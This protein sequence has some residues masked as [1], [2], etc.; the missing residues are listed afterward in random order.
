LLREFFLNKSNTD[1]STTREENPHKR[2][3]RHR[4]ERE[5]RKEEEELVVVLFLFVCVTDLFVCAASPLHT[6]LPSPQQHNTHL[7]ECTPI[8]VD[9]PSEDDDYGLLR[10]MED[11][12]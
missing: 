4:T 10:R 6:S 11:E 1:I 3:T 8:V 5:K 2:H 12:G 7:I 9:R